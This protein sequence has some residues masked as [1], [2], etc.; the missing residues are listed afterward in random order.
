[1]RGFT[2][3]NFSKRSSCAKGIWYGSSRNALKLHNHYDD[4]H[5]LRRIVIGH[6]YF[7]RVRKKNS[8]KNNIG[9]GVLSRT[10]MRIVSTV[11][12]IVVFC[13]VIGTAGLI[14]ERG[15]ASNVSNFKVATALFLELQTYIVA[16]ATSS[17]PSPNHF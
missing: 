10:F 9:A 8:P 13:V 4:H 11:I 17:V 12:I 3:S 5:A 1:M 7:D 2:W 6:A 16:A 15:L 14:L